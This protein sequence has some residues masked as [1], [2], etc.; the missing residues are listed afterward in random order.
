MPYIKIIFIFIKF[1]KKVSITFLQNMELLLYQL[2]KNSYQKNKDQCN[3]QIATLHF[4]KIIIFNFLVY[5]FLISI[6]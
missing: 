2:L 5:L 6:A 3:Y 1:V 4:L